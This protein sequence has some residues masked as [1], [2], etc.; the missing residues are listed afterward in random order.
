[1]ANLLTK[2]THLGVSSRIVGYRSV[3]V[4]SKGDAKCREHSDSGNTDAVKSHGYAACAHREVETVG[5]QIAEH[6]GCRDGDNGNHRGNHSRADA[7][8][9]N[10]GR[11]GLRSLRN[12]LCRLVAVACIVFRRLSDDHSCHKSA[13]NRER[14]SEPVL[15]LQEI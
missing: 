7:L 9:D 10:S 8:Y 4:G 15:N 5:K 2:F 11:T 14:H 13:D 6:D 1:M 3:C 12:L